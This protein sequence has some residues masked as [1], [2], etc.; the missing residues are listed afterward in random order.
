MSRQ[1]HLFGIL[2]FLGSCGSERADLQPVDGCD[3]ACINAVAEQVTA[4]I[5]S[6]IYFRSD[7]GLE[8]DLGSEINNS[9]ECDQGDIV[10]AGGCQ[11]ADG[12]QPRGLTESGPGNG[13]WSCTF[14][15][16]ATDIVENIEIVATAVCLD[17]S[18]L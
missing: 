4:N 3:S 15:R 1:L 7:S 8:V 5:V 14:E 11:V 17:S 18:D 6:K 16:L 2:L 9:A 12:V 10:I 13:F